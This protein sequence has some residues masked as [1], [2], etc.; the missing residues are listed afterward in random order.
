[1]RISDLK[2]KTRAQVIGF[3]IVGLIVIAVPVAFLIGTNVQQQDA[4]RQTPEALALQSMVTAYLDAIADGRVS[5]A[6][7]LDVDGRH[8]FAGEEYAQEPFLADAALEGAQERIS[9]IAVQVSNEAGKTA[10]EV[11]QVTFTL[12]GSE[13]TTDLW[14]RWSAGDEKWVLTD[15]LYQRVWV[16]SYTGLAEQPSFAKYT[17]QRPLG[18][19][20]RGADPVTTSADDPGLRLYLAY[21]AVYQVTVAAAPSAVASPSE[22]PLDQRLVVLPWKTTDTDCCGIGIRVT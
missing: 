8:V 16:S 4:R 3:T 21:P 5:D 6:M 20:I 19:E 12:N 1:M 10:T 9:N 17:D 22:T 2:R 18:F 7:A 11:A 14:S 15:S 13:Y